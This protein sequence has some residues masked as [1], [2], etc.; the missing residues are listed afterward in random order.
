M[1]LTGPYHFRLSESG[2]A[3]V[4]SHHSATFAMDAQRHAF[5]EVFLLLHGCVDVALFC[6]D[7]A[8]VDRTMRTGDCLIVPAGVRHRFDDRKASTLIVVAFSDQAL[9]NMAGRRPL[10]DQLRARIGTEF[11]VMT[12][13]GATQLGDGWR[14]LVAI[15]QSEVAR[16]EL[17]IAFSRFLLD[18][19]AVSQRPRELDARERVRDLQLKLKQRVHE[20][21][22]LDR[23]AQTTFLSRRRFSQLWREQTGATFVA[24]LQRMRVEA[25]MEL[26]T[27]HDLSVVAA[28]YSSG[29]NDLAN[30]YRVFR[31]CVGCTPGQWKQ[32]ALASQR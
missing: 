8:R 16:L 4:E 2:I 27:R 24:G 3:V 30:F 18:L 26:M 13:G 10:W 29:F 19:D 28:A 25:S 21:W 20:P 31:R 1:A 15:G 5:H 14:D 12:A 9:S 22:S 23:A 11:P 17:E 6:D 32:R 7:R